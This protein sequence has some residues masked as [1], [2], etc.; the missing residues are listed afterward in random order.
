MINM[1]LSGGLG[2]QLFQICCALRY[3]NNSAQRVQLYLDDLKS[4]K[5]PRKF[6][7]N[8]IVD[9]DFK[10]CKGFSR[11]I[12]RT[13]LPKVISKSHH[14][15]NDRN[16]CTLKIHEAAKISFLDGY[17]QFEQ[18]WIVISSA[19]S[20]LKRNLNSS[21][22]MQGS[23][24]LV[25]HARGGD[26]LDDKASH[27]HQMKF[28]E[29]ALSGSK[30]PEFKTGVLCCSD[31][32]YASEIIDF[33]ESRGITLSYKPNNDADWQEDFRILMNA[34]FILGGRSTFAWWASVLGEVDSLFPLDFTIGKPRVLFHPW[35]TTH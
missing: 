11:F 26:F 19:I 3:S 1:R 5:V 14:F 17:F 21:F 16:F 6:E 31:S 10:R 2:N 20:M 30:M 4:Y 28:Y 33:F 22:L 23:D 25:V 32:N 13:R 7:L 9:I 29:Q 18:D 15:I 27:V 35:E 34:G 24:E 12:L 8:K